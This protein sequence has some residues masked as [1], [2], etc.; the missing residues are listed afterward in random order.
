MSI[1]SVHTVINGQQYTLTL[2]SS[3]G[4]Y[5]A[6]ITAPSKSS[7]SNNEGHYYPVAI[8]ATDDAGNSTTVDDTHAT[9]GEALRLK[10]KEKVVPTVTITGPTAGATIINNKPAITAQLRDNDSGIN[11]DSI[12]LK[13][14]NTAIPVANITKTPVEGGYNISY[15]PATALADGSHT[16]SLQVSDNDGNQCAVKTNS[17][18]VDT[19]PPTL[20]ITAPV[21]GLKTNVTALTVTGITNDATSSPVTVKIKLNNVDQGAVT[22]NSQDGAFSKALT[23]TEGDNTIEVTATDSAGK[24]T[25]VTRTVTLDITAPTLSNITITPNPVDCGATYVIAVT[26]ED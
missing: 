20:S 10:V 7:Y 1:Q 17:F 3:T 24:A 8:T 25:T 12:S 18:K 14:D 4:K 5:E 9:L 26:V 22:V 21:D 15:T 11:P 13:V 16:I 19:V 2:N 23:L 6:T